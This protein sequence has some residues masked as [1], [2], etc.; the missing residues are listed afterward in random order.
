[1]K[2]RYRRAFSLL[3][4]SPCLLLLLLFPVNAN[5]QYFGRNKVNYD[6]FDFKI[7]HTKHFNIY[8][9][10]EEQDAIDYAAAMAERWYARHSAIFA[11]TLNGKQPLILYD[12]FPQFA[13]TNVTPGFIGQGTGGF[14]E[15][16]RRRVVLPFA[17]PLAETNH[18]IGH[19]LV[20]AF[21]FDL[22]SKIKSSLDGLPPASGMPLWLIEGM[23]E[24][25]S[26][27][28]NDPFTSMWMREATLSKLPKIS[29]LTNPKYFP[30]RY[31]QSLLAF[32]GGTYGDQKIT[33]LLKEATILGDVNSAID[34]VF[35]ISP[36][37]L[38]EQWH[39]ALHAEYDPL[40]KIT[41][42][43][44]DYGKVLIKGEKGE[45][46][47]NLSPAISPDGNKLVFFSSRDLFSIDLFLADA[48][49]GK[50]IKNIFK[51]E[52]NTHLQDLEFINS[53][54]SWSPDSK[55][56]VFAAVKDGRPSIS[57]LNTENGEIERTVRFPKLAEIFSSAWSPDSRYIV[58]SALY[59]GF[60]NLFVYDLTGGV[61]NQLTDDVFAELHPAWS[62]DGKS[63]A[64]STDRFTTDLSDLKIGNYELAEVNLLTK[65]IK[66]LNSFP[67][68]KNINP[69]WSPDGKSIYFISNHNGISNLYKLNLNNDEIEQITNL[70][71]GISGVTSISPA[72]SV[73]K[74]KNKLVFSVYEK[75]NYSIYSIDSTKLFNGSQ[76]LENLVSYSPG[77]LPPVQ[78]KQSFFLKNLENPDIGLSGKIAGKIN[79][80]HPSLFLIGISQPSVAA[81]ID[82]FGTYL[83]GG[84]VMF[85]SDMLGNYNLATALQAQ[86]GSGFTNISGMVGYTNTANRWNW[87]GVV[88]QVPYIS[89]GFSSGYENVDNIP[90]YFEQDFI[91]EELH[92]SIT[93][94]L[95]YP[96]SQVMRVEF[97]AGYTNIS[98]SNKVTTRAISL[99]DQSELINKTE[100]LPH[101]APFDLVSLSTAL[102]Y[103]NSYM[104]ATGPLLG[105]RYR[106]EVTPMFGTLNWVN[107][108]A[109]YR[110]YF[111]PVRPFTIAA[112]IMQVG[113]YGKN[114][115]DPRILPLFLGYPEL[116]RGYSN[117]SFSQGEFTA[118]GSSP[119]YENLWGSKILVANIEL[120]FPIFGALG[121]GDG[122]Y[123]YFPIEAA[124]F[125]DAG[126][127]WTNNDKPDF[128]GGDR[129]PVSSVGAGLRVNL[130]G[131]VVAEVDY[132]H[133]F[134]RP[135]KSWLWQFKLS[136]GF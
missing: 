119:A 95:A 40:A 103:D 57:I 94:T 13:E 131:Y 74:S 93:G 5:A 27:G 22:S 123:G 9:Y 49:T 114:A 88:Q 73:A 132:V 29:D 11:D 102:V 56:F 83:G 126:V 105:S 3:N 118:D 96:F 113:R 61:L 35:K 125:Y 81:G 104:G 120:R 60:S 68:S 87:G 116:V 50:I 97:G 100:D 99:N 67:D 37:S 58:F 135:Q 51:K 25:F 4:F 72:I 77:K 128:L 52:F 30:Y 44:K 19:E 16:Y 122:F 98:F 15:P 112:R 106:F 69:Q 48:N 34:S 21:Q 129:K 33:D 14:T 32:I 111:M 92:R 91:S 75:G 124:L 39:A 53:T 86:I 110:Q 18:V 46:S 107:T 64:F 101:P 12:G 10:E 43:P 117:S 136:Q 24:Y 130:M 79:N 121:L 71:G 108:L 109:D 115:D 85:W 55:K 26:L 127:A 42:R 84:I 2:K 6:T 54:G 31:G 66:K 1:M 8:F 65:E 23:A 20:H 47:I 76:E 70:F 62:P 7:L 59:K 41:K 90:A 63:I 134:D 28:P 45:K 133:P 17:G 36:D 82:R 38:S 80:Y 89:R 78:R